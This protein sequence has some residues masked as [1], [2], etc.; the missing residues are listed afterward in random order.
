MSRQPG[1]CTCY[2]AGDSHPALESML[3]FM[4]GSGGGACSWTLAQL[5]PTQVEEL[6]SAACLIADFAVEWR[7]KGTTHT[8]EIWRDATNSGVKLIGVDR[9]VVTPYLDQVFGLPEKP[10]LD[11]HRRG[12]LAELIWYLLAEHIG[13]PSGRVLRRIEGPDWHPTKPG[14]DG[15]VIWETS[16]GNLEF[17][18]WESKQYTGAGTVSGSISDATKQI[19][20]NA[21]QYLAQA[22]A[23]GAANGPVSEADVRQLYGELVS[24]WIAK[25]PKAGIGISVTTSHANAPRRAFSRVQT[26]FPDLSLPGQLEGLISTVGNFQ[27]FADDVRNRVWNALLI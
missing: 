14:G 9:E 22:T 7:C 23:I 18:L 20:N 24:L 12:W 3:A 6:D 5:K 16:P 25:S 27:D 15:L 8:Y 1:A 19:R 10:R 11:I 4:P 17:R 26:T 2:L 21:L 13:S